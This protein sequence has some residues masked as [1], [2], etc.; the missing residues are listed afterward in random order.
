MN[1]TS[2]TE[3]V[4]NPAIFLLLKKVKHK[5]QEI[6]RFKLQSKKLVAIDFLKLTHHSSLVRQPP[7]GAPRLSLII[8]HS[9]LIPTP[10]H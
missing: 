3:K 2:E 7:R 10:S 4:F 5:E 1:P 9:S 6:Y 8:H